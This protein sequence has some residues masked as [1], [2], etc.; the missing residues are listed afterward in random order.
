MMVGSCC[1]E[2][3]LVVSLVD[4]LGVVGDW[5]VTKLADS[6]DSIRFIRMAEHTE[7]GSEALEFY[8]NKNNIVNRT[9]NGLS[10]CRFH[11]QAR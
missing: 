7:H 5:V 2:L 3:L 10:I 8:S 11:E 9:S 1:V 6:A 4:V